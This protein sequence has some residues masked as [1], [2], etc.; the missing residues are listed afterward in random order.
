[1][2]FDLQLKITYSR[3]RDLNVKGNNERG[4][5]YTAG[6][7]GA[8][9]ALAPSG[10]PFAGSAGP[11]TPASSYQGVGSELL[12]GGGGGPVGPHETPPSGELPSCK[13]AKENMEVLRVSSNL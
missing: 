6:A 11:A 3:H 5:D 1:M 8:P 12:M 10:Q 13:A 2:L 4:M 9:P 7:G